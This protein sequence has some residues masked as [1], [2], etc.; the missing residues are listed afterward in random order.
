[1]GK[2]YFKSSNSATTIV[3]FLVIV[4]V[5]FTA[6]KKTDV[7]NP[8]AGGSDTIIK[9]P[10]PIIAAINPIANADAAYDGFLKAFLVRSGGKTYIT[11]GLVDRG[12]AY[13]WGQGFMITAM[14]D[15]YAKN[16]SADRKK[17]VSNLL[18]TFIADNGSDWSWDSWNDDVA[19]AIIPFIRGYQ[20]TGNITYLTIARQNWNMVWDRGW[21]NVVGGGVWENQDKFSKAALSNDPTIIAGCFIYESIGDETYLTRCKQIYTWVRSNLFNAGT[22][23]VNEALTNASTLQPSDNAYNCGS[24][25]NAAASLYKETKDIQYLNDAQIAADHIISKFGVM[26]EEGDGCVRGIAKLARENNLGNKYNPWLVRQCIASWN[27]RRADY[28]ISNNDWRSPTP[29]GEQFAMQCVSAVTLEAVTPEA[30]MVTVPDGVYK[31]ISHDNGL[32]LDAAGSG[33]TN[34]TSLNVMAYN[35]GDN[36]HWTLTGLGGGLYK[37]IGIGSGRSINVSGNSGDDNAAL[38]LWDYNNAGNE[39]V[40]LSSPA[41]GY[42]SMFFVNSGKA[43]SVTA[44]DK[45]SGIIQSAYTGNTNQQWQFL[46]P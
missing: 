43:V 20:I 42:Y 23:V 30:E 3:K 18:N 36:Q 15:A 1:M 35:N 10:T 22:G 7:N 41:A 24:F 11:N 12:E 32:A 21:D 39:I 25:I 31:V 26:N 28:N 13:M 27:N 38:I 45:G 37:F 33:T 34:N 5:M 29:T 6:C 4:A 40:Y 2:K 8:K 44:V 19:W 16:N 17:L 14:E 46:K 9:P